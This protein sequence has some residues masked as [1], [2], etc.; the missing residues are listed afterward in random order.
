MAKSDVNGPNA[1]EAFKYLRLR[2][3]LFDQDK[4]EAKVIPWNFSKFLV[5]ADLSV[6]EF[7]SPTVEL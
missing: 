6:I 2:S 5:N 4:N 1:N 3:K 7:H